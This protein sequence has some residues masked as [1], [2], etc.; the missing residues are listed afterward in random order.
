MSPRVFGPRVGTHF[1]RMWNGVECPSK[2][3]GSHVVRTN[4]A[5]RGGEA[6]AD[7]AADDQKILVDHPGTGQAHRLFVRR[8]AQILSKVDAAAVAEADDRLAS[9]PIECIQILIDAGKDAGL[10][11]ISPVRDAAIGPP[12]LEP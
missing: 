12:A 3:T 7:A 1:A 9:L 10:G 5:R 2:G 8:A 4:V 6:L 11:S